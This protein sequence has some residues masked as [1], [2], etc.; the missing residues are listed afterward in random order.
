LRCVAL[1]V[2]FRRFIVFFYRRGDGHARR[3]AEQQ[4]Q[5][6]SRGR[7]ERADLARGKIL[8]WASDKPRAA[9][10]ALTAAVGPGRQSR[11]LDSS[12]VKFSGASAAPAFPRPPFLR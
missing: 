12:E 5:T 11:A 4:Q 1:R 10:G 8:L 6:G 2:V 3:G 9:E 7:V